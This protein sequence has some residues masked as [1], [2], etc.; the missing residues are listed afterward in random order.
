[1][2]AS[3]VADP[4]WPLR[5]LGRTPGRGTRTTRLRCGRV[6]AR[7]GPPRA[8][9]APTA[10]GGALEPALLD[11][12][13]IARTQDDGALHDVLQ[14]AFVPGPVVGSKKFERV[15]VDRPHQFPH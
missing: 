1:M 9:P 3:A 8:W 7:R 2:R 12:K 6:R 10:G 4:A 11:R 14:F 5:R 15:S 13:G